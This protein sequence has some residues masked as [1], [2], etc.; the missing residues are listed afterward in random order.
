VVLAVF[1]TLAALYWWL[2]LRGP[3]ERDFTARTPA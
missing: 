3:F 2:L 1:A